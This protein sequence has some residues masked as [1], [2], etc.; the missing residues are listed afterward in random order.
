M[1][2]HRRL[3][4]TLTLGAAAGLAAEAFAQAGK[5][6]I[7]SAPRHDGSAWSA[8]PFPAQ[9]Q[10]DDV[11]GPDGHAIDR[12]PPNT[13][14]TNNEPPLPA[15][16]VAIFQSTPEVDASAV[17]V[18]PAAPAPVVVAQTPAEPAPVVIAQTPAEP[19]LTPTGR[20]TVAVASTLDAAMY[21]PTIR[22]ST[23]E[24]RAQ[25]VADIENRLTASE[26][27]LAS[28]KASASSMNDDARKSFDTAHDDVKA[29]EKA[30]RKSIE[31]ANKADASEWE[32]ARAQLAADYDAYAAAVASLDAS[33][34]LR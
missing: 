15:P 27:A 2:A 11:K 17:A 4:I 6:V 26:S 1:K 5:P 19:V 28:V 34:G 10:F 14:A 16:R 3:L 29:K 18:A 24:A 25:T 12:L 7:I 20:S 9:R 23:Y 31:A 32:N 33:A 13:E 8:A 22:A 21:S 30:L